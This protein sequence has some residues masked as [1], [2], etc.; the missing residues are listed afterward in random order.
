MFQFKCW[1]LGLVITGK[2]DR[3]L[4]KT[5]ASERRPF[6]QALIDFDHK[7]SRLFSGR[8]AKDMADEMV[9]LIFPAYVVRVVL[10]SWEMQG[11]SMDVF[12]DGM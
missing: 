11:V 3:G 6:A 1:K 10:T 12:K 2:A 8:P 4:L 7:F 9:S 5:Y